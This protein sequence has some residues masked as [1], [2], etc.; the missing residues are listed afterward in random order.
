VKFI[1][2]SLSLLVASVAHAGPAEVVGASVGKM[3]KILASGG[4]EASKVS[5]LCT[6]ARQQV[7]SNTI[8]AELLGRQFRT[9]ARDQEGVRNFMRL[10][11]SILVSEF[12]NR[13]SGLGTD[14]TVN[15]NLIAKGSSRVG[16]QIM[17]GNKRLVVT[18]N[19]TTGKVLDV[20]YRGFS[21]VNNKKAEYQRDMNAWLNRGGSNSLPVTQLVNSLINS[22][23]LIRCN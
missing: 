23:N 7:E 3:L 19:K 22:G 15:P 2:L 9:L 14:Y 6:L 18:A 11:P 16:V 10:V 4:S 5:G 13:L 17:V 20:E 1:I 8:G 12:Y 21:L